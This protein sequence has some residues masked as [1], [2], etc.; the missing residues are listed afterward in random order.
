MAAAIVEGA[1]ARG[2]VLG[3]APE[4]VTTITGRG[5]EATVEGH[6]VLIGTRRLLSE[7]SIAF[8]SV[9]ERLIAL[10]QQGKTVMIVVIDSN[11]AGS[12]CGG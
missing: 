9:E 10:E 3:A 8:D 6:A 11:V 12:G 2:L 1:K 7:R 4:Q 5:L